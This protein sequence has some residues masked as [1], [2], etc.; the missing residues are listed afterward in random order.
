M[1]QKQDNT[2]PSKKRPKMEGTK[3]AVPN[4][5][6]VQGR[7]IGE[8]KEQIKNQFSD[9]KQGW[10]RNG[11]IPWEDGFITDFI[12]KKIEE[13]PKHVVLFALRH[14]ILI[15]Y[16]SS[17][18]YFERLQEEYH[19]DQWVWNE[20]SSAPKRWKKDK[21][22]DTPTVKDVWSKLERDVE[23]LLEGKD[24]I[25]KKYKKEENKFRKFCFIVKVL[26]F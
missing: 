21:L 7:E 25:D 9:D 1:E 24:I 2:Q 16:L 22:N 19:V 20:F 5:L 3:E 18:N 17:D 13:K 6:S 14:I 8:A 12:Q 26:V 15:W 23:L 4:A 10:N 11:T